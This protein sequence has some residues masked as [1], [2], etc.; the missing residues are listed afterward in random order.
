MKRK[1]KILRWHNKYQYLS[2][3]GQRHCKPAGCVPHLWFCPWAGR[4]STWMMIMMMMAIMTTTSMMLLSLKMVIT[5]KTKSNLPSS[6]CT[7]LSLSFNFSFSSR[8]RDPSWISRSD[9]VTNMMECLVEV[10]RLPNWHEPGASGL[11]SPTR[12]G[13]TFTK[14]KLL[15]RKLRMILTEHLIE[16]ISQPGN[17]LVLA[18]GLHFCH[19]VRLIF[20]P[21]WWLRSIW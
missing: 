10:V 19:L 9:R 6:S 17:C 3:A 11:G 5:L 15:R 18:A 13:R 2:S 4:L 1:N 16:K 7:L 20:T 12:S 14:V 8:P 21:C